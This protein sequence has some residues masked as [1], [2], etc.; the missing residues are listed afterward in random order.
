MT[1]IVDVKAGDILTGKISNVTHFGAFVDVGLGRVTSRMFDTPLLSFEF[2][3]YPLLPL[4]IFSS[5]L[6]LYSTLPCPPLSPHYSIF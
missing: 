6:L 2:L 5:S 4:V 1:R 3:L